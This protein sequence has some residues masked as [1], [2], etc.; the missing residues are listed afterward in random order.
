MT[1]EIPS[2]EEPS[3]DTS[4]TPE[5]GVWAAEIWATTARQ[6]LSHKLIQL[7]AD[8]GADALRE[9]DTIDVLMDELRTF[10]P[11]KVQI[12]STLPPADDLEAV[13]TSLTDY[14][15]RIMLA[16]NQAI[17]NNISAIKEESRLQ[18]KP[19][20]KWRT[21]TEPHRRMLLDWQLSRVQ[22]A[23]QHFVKSVEEVDGPN[24]EILDGLLK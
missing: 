16:A 7:L 5:D 24:R 13:H 23:R 22:E 20:K 21:Q 19:L 17:H 18:G 10:V 2:Y 4:A 3:E 11:L 6:I 8:D 14:A 9:A 15:R 12:E 1:N